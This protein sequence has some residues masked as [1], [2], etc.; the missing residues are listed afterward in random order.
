M[1]NKVSYLRVC[2]SVQ[3]GKISHTKGKR[4]CVVLGCGGLNR[5]RIGF[6]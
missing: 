1:Y 5:R 3:M 4:G 2:A 6:P